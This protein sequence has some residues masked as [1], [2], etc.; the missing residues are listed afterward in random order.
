MLWQR[1]S[2]RET[3]RE[4]IYPE[5]EEAG[6]GGMQLQAKE[7]RQPPEAGRGREQVLL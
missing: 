1:V 2:I 7:C 3:Q 6:I 4:I 5:E